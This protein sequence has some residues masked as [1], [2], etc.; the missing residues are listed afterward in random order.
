MSAIGAKFDAF[1]DKVSNNYAG[2]AGDLA[3]I[4]NGF[5]TATA[6]VA[7]VTEQA[8]GAMANDWGGLADYVVESNAKIE[9]SLKEGAET[10]KKQA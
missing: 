4:S 8:V 7:G 10:S 6:N 1:G 5:K 3:S 9:T 2:I